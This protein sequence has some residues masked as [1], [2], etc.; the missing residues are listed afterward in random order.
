MNMDNRNVMQQESSG[1]GQPYVNSTVYD[2]SHAIYQDAQI[3][4]YRLMQ[5]LRMEEQYLMARLEVDRKAA[6]KLNH[7]SIGLQT[8]DIKL[9][10]QEDERVRRK[11]QYEQVSLVDGRVQV[12]IRNLRIEMPPTIVSNIQYP[13]LEILRRITDDTDMAYRIAFSIGEFRRAAYFDKG[14]VGS[15]AYLLQRF[16]AEGALFKADA[17]ARKK[18]YAQQL[19]AYLLNQ[20]PDVRWIADREGWVKLPGGAWKYI[21]KEEITWQKVRKLCC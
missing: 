16:A 4:Q 6:E 17:M 7:D 9:R 3:N 21:G 15:G 11:S 19:L 14:K 8:Y 20:N 13:I 12:E 1:V 5:Q 2:G 10:M 18:E